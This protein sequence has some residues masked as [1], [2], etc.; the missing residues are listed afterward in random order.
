MSNLTK[1]RSPLQY[2]DESGGH[3]QLIKSTYLQFVLISNSD[4]IVGTELAS[5]LIPGTEIKPNVLA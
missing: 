1:K 4:L 3:P 5:S 2:E